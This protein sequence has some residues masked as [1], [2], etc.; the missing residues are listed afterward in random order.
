MLK[1]I[2]SKENITFLIAVLG[3][4]L[5]ASKWFYDAWKTR[6]NLA[7]TVDFNSSSACTYMSSQHLNSTFAF[8]FVN[9][10]ANPIAVTCICIESNGENEYRCE[11]TPQFVSHRFR[12][13]IDTETQY[14]ERFEESAEFPIQISAYGAAYEYISF[15]LPK[16]FDPNA[17]NAV[18]I[19]TNHGIVRISDTKTI[20]EFVRFLQP[21][22]VRT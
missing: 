5:S 16:E 21:D 18:R 8:A 20:R 11:L 1:W 17:V 3:F 4:A 22:L 10:S 15:Q 14:Y 2:Q 12:R 6:K 9:K 13:L 19:M 7:V